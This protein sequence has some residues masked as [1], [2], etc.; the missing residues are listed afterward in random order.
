MARKKS[1]KDRG[2]CPLTSDEE[3]RAAA[4]K[5]AA[6]IKD[7]LPAGLSRPALRALASAGYKNLGQLAKV[8]EADLAKLHGFGPKGVELIRAALKARGKSFRA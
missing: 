2:V 1:K 8:R 7:A 4:D 6:S 3:L 5:M